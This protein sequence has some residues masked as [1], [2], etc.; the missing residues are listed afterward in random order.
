LKAEKKTIFVITHRTSILRVVDKVLLLVNGTSQAYGPRD[1]VLARL[2]KEPAPAP[3]LQPAMQ[4]GQ[5]I[6]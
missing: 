5:K 4:A 6:R 3:R 2:K 1:E